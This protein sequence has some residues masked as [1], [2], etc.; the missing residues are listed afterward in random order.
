MD[1][2]PW[3][4]GRWWQIVTPDGHVC[5]ETSDPREVV[6]QMAGNPTHTILKWWRREQGE[7]RIEDLDTVKELARGRTR[8]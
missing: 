6:E 7:W 8:R 5:M 1:E 2:E 3:V 4:R